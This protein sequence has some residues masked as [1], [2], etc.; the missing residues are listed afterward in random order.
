ML[1]LQ[2]KVTAELT[3]KKTIAD[4]GSDCIGRE[5][6]E[7]DLSWV[8]SHSLSLSL[9]YTLENR[10]SF[11]SCRLEME[12]S[13]G[14]R[15]GREGRRWRRALRQGSRGPQRMTDDLLTWSEAP[16]SRWPH[17]VR[18]VSCGNPVVV[19]LSSWCLVSDRRPC[20]NSFLVSFWRGRLQLS[21]E[22]HE[23]LLGGAGHRGGGRERP[24]EV[25]SGCV[26][27][28]LLFDAES[29]E[30]K[31]RLLGDSLT[32]CSNFCYILCKFVLKTSGDFSSTRLLTC[33]VSIDSKDGV[34][35]FIIRF[36]FHMCNL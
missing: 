31:R 30:T 11:Y 3:Q 9:T 17:Q 6:R 21:D 1:S 29:C 22:V 25:R 36:S 4:S 24:E 28:W 33:M 19:V 5:E 26:Q 14:G 7:V 32:F 15:E 35:C 10:A 8:V 18:L 23:V 16:A 12:R 20:S 34:H 27:Y 13:G 2:C